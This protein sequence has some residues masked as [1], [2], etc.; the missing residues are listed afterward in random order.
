[1]KTQFFMAPE[2]RICPIGFAGG[3]IPTIPANILL[4]KNLTVVGCNLGYYVGWSP[5]DARF[6]QAE[7][8]AA[9]HRR[10]Y[11]WVE[12]GRLRPHIGRTFVLEQVPAAIRAILDR[13]V[14]GRVAIVMT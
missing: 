13:H 3:T 4:V 9:L 8:V 12:A 5:H 6:E 14:M 11:D 10:L 7:R 1:M 2:A